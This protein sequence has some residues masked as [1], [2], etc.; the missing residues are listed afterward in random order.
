MEPSTNS[1][2]TPANLLLISAFIMSI[3]FSVWNV[4]LNNFVVNM[5]NFTGKEIGILQ[6]LRDPRLFSFYCDLSTSI[7]S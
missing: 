4:L 2:Y 3:T 7:Y 1:R 5:A 6:S